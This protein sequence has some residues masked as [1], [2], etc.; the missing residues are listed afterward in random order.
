MYAPVLRLVLDTLPRRLITVG[1]SILVLVGT[2]FLIP[3]VNISFLGDTGQ[4]I[5]SLTQ[6]LPAGTNLEQSSEKATESEEALLEIDGVDTV[7]TTIGGGQFGMGGGGGN[8]VS[9]SITT[10]PDADQGALLDDMV[11]A[12][13]ALPEAGTIEAA[14]IASPTGSSSVDILITGPTPRI[15]RPRT[16]RSSPSSTRCP[17]ASPRSAATC[18]PTSPPQWSPWTGR[19]P[20][21]WG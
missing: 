13:E 21:S 16:T 12:L 2:V 1:A 10:D 20:H 11:A 14:D 17:T 19:P 8:E 6:T 3:L 15:A 4:N 9:F 18:S 7:Q 5:A